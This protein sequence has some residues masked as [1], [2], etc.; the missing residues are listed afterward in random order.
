[1]DKIATPT[2]TREILNKYG[3]RLSKR[4]GQNFLVDPVA[5]ER[6]VS[7]ACDKGDYVVEIGPG[8]GS[9][10]QLLL[11]RAKKV[12]AVE[13]DPLLVNVLRE[14]FKGFDN[15]VVMEGNALDHPLDHLAGQY[16]PDP[17][18][19]KIVGN[20]PYYV[21]TPIL[22]HIF[23][24]ASSAARA[25]VMLQK[26]VADRISAKPG[27]KSYG[28]L[29]VASQYY[30]QPEIILRVSHKLFFPQPEVESVV[31]RLDVRDCPPVKVYDTQMFFRVVRAAFNQRRKT[32]VNALSNVLPELS[33]EQAAGVLVEAGIDPSRRGETLSI[34]DFASIANK[35]CELLREEEE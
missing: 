34:S 5:A 29:S 4:R 10:T 13:I 27:G 33:K 22:F 17:A 16:F 14:E 6:I 25:T 31:L 12:V 7:N 18:G 23:E 19:Y 28:S 21:T 11:A 20:L 15:L 24:T 26:E 32:V 30:S 1:M 8:I 35:A 9:L 2:K 3:I